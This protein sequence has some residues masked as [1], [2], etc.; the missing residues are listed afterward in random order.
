MDCIF[1]ALSQIQWPPKRFAPH[2]PIHSPTV[3]ESSVFIDR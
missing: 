2:S 1:I 3:Y